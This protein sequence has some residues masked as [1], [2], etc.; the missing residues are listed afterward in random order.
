MFRYFGK[1]RGVFAAGLVLTAVLAVTM[2]VRRAQGPVWIAVIT[3]LLG[4]PSD[5]PQS[6]RNRIPPV[7]TQ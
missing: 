3:V 5:A 7:S 1:S 4:N 6:N 2:G